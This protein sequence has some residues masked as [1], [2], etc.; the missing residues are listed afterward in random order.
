MTARTRPV[1]TQALRRGAQVE[2]D[3]GGSRS[4]GPSSRD[5]RQPGAGTG[6]A[7]ASPASGSMA[8]KSRS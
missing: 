3:A 4:S 1:G 6:A 7:G 5:P 2:P 8:A